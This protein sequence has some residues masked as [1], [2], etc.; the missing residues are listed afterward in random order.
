MKCNVDL[1][2]E[3]TLDI[4]TCKGHNGSTEEPRLP[5]TYIAPHRFSFFFLSYLKFLCTDPVFLLQSVFWFISLSVAELIGWA[6]RF[7][8]MNSITLTCW[9]FI[10]GN[11]KVWIKL[12]VRTRPHQRMFC[13]TMAR[14]LLF[15]YSLSC[16]SKRINVIVYF[17]RI[18]C[19]EIYIHT[20][21]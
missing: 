19:D 21:V 15:I 10:I 5:L 13:I 9:T 6:N 11:E 16:I 3:S 1:H 20:Y 12:I 8:L 18:D 14:S 4:E 17:H 2:A 7:S